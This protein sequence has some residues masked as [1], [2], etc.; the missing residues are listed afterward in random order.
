MKRI[1]SFY[2]QT[3]C[4]LCRKL[5]VPIE[6]QGYARARA[7]ESV[8]VLFV[9]FGVMFNAVNLYRDEDIRFRG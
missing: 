5:L 3:N 9:S 7:T 6:R 8:I 1:I 2:L 4:V